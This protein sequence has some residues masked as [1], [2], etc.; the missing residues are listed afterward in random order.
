MEKIV[1]DLKNYLEVEY[2]G[3]PS[4]CETEGC[5]QMGV[6]GRA[7]LDADGKRRS[8]WLCHECDKAMSR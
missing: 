3:R 8:E 2:P 4:R 5:D 6:C 7:T 1:R